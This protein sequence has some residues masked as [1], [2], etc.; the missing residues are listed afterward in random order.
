VVAAVIVSSVCVV[1]EA[2]PRQWLAT[3]AAAAVLG[4]IVDSFLGAWLERR[5]LINNDS[6]N[7][8]STLV[9]ALAAFWLA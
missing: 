3:S 5:H 1:R 6:V 9:A 7:F 8:L 4:M 2:L